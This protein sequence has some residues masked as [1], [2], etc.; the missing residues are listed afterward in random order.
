MHIAQLIIM[1]SNASNNTIVYVHMCFEYTDSKIGFNNELFFSLIKRAH[2]LF[3]DIQGIT[4]TCVDLN[5]CV[6]PYC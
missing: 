1:L 4:I 2:L 6:Y 5:T 3:T